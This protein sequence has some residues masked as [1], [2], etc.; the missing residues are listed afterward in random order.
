[1]SRAGDR[2]VFGF[3][4]WRKAPM[5]HRSRDS[6]NLLKLWFNERRPLAR[7]RPPPL[8]PL[9]VSVLAV[10]WKRSRG[11]PH[12]HPVFTGADLQAP[13][14]PSFRLSARCDRARLDP[15]GAAGPGTNATRV[16]APA[17][18]FRR[19]RRRLNRACPAYYADSRASQTRPHPLVSWLPS[20]RLVEKLDRRSHLHR[21]RQ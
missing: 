14:H 15:S 19:A 4:G 10:R 18:G 13:A 8:H 20:L 5:C 16:E 21:P 11:A 6:K 2:C 3:G 9:T 1:M 17:A 7:H 12:R